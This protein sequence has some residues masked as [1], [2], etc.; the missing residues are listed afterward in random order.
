MRRETLVLLALAVTPLGCTVGE[1][2][3]IVEGMIFINNCKGDLRGGPRFPYGDTPEQHPYS[4]KSEFVAAEPIQDIA[5]GPKTHRLIIR[6][7]TN[8]RRREA[9]DV[10]KFDVPDSREVARCVRGRIDP[11]TMMPDFD[12]DNC[13]WPAGATVARLRVA[14]NGL[15][16]VNF[17]PN[18]ICN[19]PIV[20][21]AIS[22]PVPT[23]PGAWDSWVELK[24]FGSAAQPDLPPTER[25]AVS[26]EFKVNFDQQLTAPSFQLKIE[27]DAVVK[28]PLLG[29][30]LPPS[31]INGTL[32]GLF[33]FD[34]QR[35]QGAQTFP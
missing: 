20:G 3:A 24:N 31:G 35:G 1:G 8:G 34:M 26:S 12:K 18:F 9:N 29:N 23:A 13:S 22:A 25:Q 19:V 32:T 16:R 30:P 2:T 27:D 28:A 11:Q 6:I 5:I 15:V 7:Q 17:T 4:L 14:P 33:D 21:T 10:L